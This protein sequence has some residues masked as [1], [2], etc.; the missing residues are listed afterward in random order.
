MSQAT[1]PTSDVRPRA[2]ALL[3]GLLLLPLNAFWLVQMEMGR[4][5]GPYPTTFSLYANVVF[6]LVGLTALNALLARLRPATALTPLELLVVAAMLS[7]GSSISSVDFLDVLVPMLG[8]PT[9]FAD[10]SNNWATKILPYLPPGYVVRDA[11]ALRGWYEGNAT[12][13]DPRVLRAWLPVVTYW[14]LFALALLGAMLALASLLRRRWVEQERLAFPLVMVPLAI[15]DPATGFWRQRALWHGLLVGAGVTLLNGVQ[16]FIPAAPHFPVKYVDLGPQFSSPP[17]NALGWTP[18]SMYPFAI[19]LG[20]LLPVDLL[21]SCWFCYL[22]FKLERLAG[23]YLGLTGAVPRYPYVEEQCA[24]AYYAVALAAVWTGRHYLGWMLRQVRQPGTADRA[25]LLGYRAAL[26]LLLVCVGYLVACFRHA[27][28]PLQIAA[29]GFA[30]YFLVV[31]ACA[32]MRAELAPP[33]HDLHNA[34]PERLLTTFFGPRAFKPRELTV[35][36]YFFWFNRAYRSLAIAPQVESLKIAERQQV[37]P[38]VFLAPLLL[39]AVVGV[40]VGFW[41]HLDLGYRWGA[42]S[43]MA[44]HMAWFGTEA[45]RRLDSWLSAP[46]KPDLP[47]CGALLAGGLQALLLQAARLR[48]AGW[49][50][51]PLGLAVAGSY[52]IGTTWLPLLVAWL[53]KVNVMRHGG[54]KL[55]RRLLPFFIGLVLGDYLAGCT[56]PLVGWLLG[57]PTSSFQQ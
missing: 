44:G 17:W 39:A 41:A 11:E 22:W 48:W 35:L 13:Y 42:S 23:A 34:G 1:P 33:A 47:A 28:L 6:L 8:H 56:W 51:H 46:L 7:I 26:L 54:V 2:R 53:I 29:A 18:V 55:Y 24:G 5:G 32:R 43:K 52:S 20:F 40:L 3:V 57:V 27:G 15:C 9:R 12:C 16:S 25:E 45:F 4:A 31:L 21:F 36:T 30:L 49:P 37:A 14:S 38:R 10:A 19:G 50:F